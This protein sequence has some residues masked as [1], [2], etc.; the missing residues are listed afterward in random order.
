MIENVKCINL[1]SCPYHIIIIIIIIIIITPITYNN[2]NG[3][4]FS[5][6]EEIG[7]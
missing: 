7:D 2:N 5:M 4:F 3:K 6:R 1:L